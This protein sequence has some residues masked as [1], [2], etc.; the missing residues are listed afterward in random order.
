MI[1]FVVVWCV[2]GR[3]ERERENA[4]A[5]RAVKPP[6]VIFSPLIFLSFSLSLSLCTRGRASLFHFPLLLIDAAAAPPLL[7]HHRPLAS[8][9]SSPLPPLLH[10][11]HRKHAPSHARRRR[12][13][14]LGRLRERLRGLARA[15][16]REEEGRC[17]E[18]IGSGLEKEVP[19]R[20]RAQG[21]RPRLGK[22]RRLR[23]RQVS[24]GEN[25]V[26]E[27]AGRGSG[28]GREK[29]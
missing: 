7:L 6:Y 2:S 25:E 14:G 19:S 22:V 29:K 11:L 23:H 20:R 8:S 28:E 24:A 16:G 18:E 26:G 17:V 5:A 15:Q 27:S 1:F 10:P 9:S 4:A 3:G 21:P 12:P 13:L